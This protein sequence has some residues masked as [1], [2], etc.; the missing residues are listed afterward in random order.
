M[1]R[2]AAK[3]ASKIANYA[4]LAKF[5]TGQ[6]FVTRLLLFLTLSFVLST[7]PST[8]A[9]AF[10]HKQIVQFSH[11]RILLNLLNTLQ[12]FRH[13]AN[14]IIYVYSSSFM[15]EE[16]TKCLMCKDTEYEQAQAMLGNQRPSVAIQFLR[17][18]EHQMNVNNL[19]EMMD[20]NTMSHT[21]NAGFGK[22]NQVALQEM[23]A[24]DPDMYYHVLYYYGKNMAIGGLNGQNGPK[25]VSDDQDSD[26]DDEMRINNR[27]DDDEENNPN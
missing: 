15:R 18:I 19:D 11:G 2:D 9:Y 22:L 20:S 26:S 17:Q 7:L 13:S 16:L 3:S 10:W 14:W 27:K 6:Q 1:T 5:R 12:F 21:T 25:K 4:S 8:I 24:N 23:I